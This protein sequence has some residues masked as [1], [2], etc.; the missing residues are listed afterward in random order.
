MNLKKM[1][2]AALLVP[3][4][5]FTLSANFVYANET[6]HE[7][8]AHPCVHKADCPCKAAHKECASDCKCCD[9]HKDAAHE[10]HHEA[11]PHH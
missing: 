8:A 1:Y 11:A 10:E 6:H 3:A 9:E 5:V 7:Q 2:F 4:V